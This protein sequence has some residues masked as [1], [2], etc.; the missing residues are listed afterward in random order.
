M[1]K[2]ETKAKSNSLTRH[3]SKSIKT[4]Q[5]NNKYRSQRAAFLV[6]DSKVRH[7][8]ITWYFA[9]EIPRRFTGI[10]RYK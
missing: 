10:Y 2:G 1:N 5:R 8:L 7:V 6:S 3:I 4:L 9:S